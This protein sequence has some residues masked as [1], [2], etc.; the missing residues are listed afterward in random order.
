MTTAGAPS[1]KEVALIRIPRGPVRVVAA[2][3]NTLLSMLLAASVGVGAEAPALIVGSPRPQTRLLITAYCACPIC[4]GKWSDGITASG[5]SATA[6]RTIACD[7]KRYQMGTVLLIEGV[8]RRVCEDTGAAIVG[9]H[10]DEF[11][12]THEYALQLGRRY[13]D[14]S[15]LY[16]P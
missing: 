1:G 11:V 14:A 4:C 9:A 5:T 10:V 3:A 8:G 2:V 7:R 12:D 16:A 15:V 13:A 6:G